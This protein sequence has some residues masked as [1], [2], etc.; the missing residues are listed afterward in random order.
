MKTRMALV[1]L[2]ALSFIGLARPVAALPYSAEY[3]FGDSL[4]DNGN[5]AE[6]LF[7]AN[8]P[9]PPSYH[10]SFTN[11]PVATQLLANSLGLQLAPSLWVTGFTDQYHLFGPGFTPGTNY[12]VAGATSALP[13]GASP[14][15]LAVQVGAY[16]SVNTAA[17]PAA[18]YVIMIGGNDV[19]RAARLTTGAASQTAAV[20]AGVQAELTA[21]QSLAAL[22][23][24][25]FFVVNVPNVGVI[26]EFAMGDPAN[27]PAATQLSQQYDSLLASGIGGLALPGRKIT[28]FDLYGFNANIL[29]NAASYGLTDKTD[30]CYINTPISAATSPQCGPSAQNIGSFAYWDAIHPTAQVQA[31][32]ASGFEAALGVPEPP[33]AALIGGALFGILALGWGRSLRAYTFVPRRSRAR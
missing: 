13:P 19:R 15:S 2:A 11:G 10:D 20:A 6:V 30:P 8:F 4:S 32:W 25:N 3:V 21:I 7:N 18:L 24:R 16:A 14:I 22:G 29:A 17:D 28:Q 12:A 5:L 9:N 31:L 23:A 1:G 27:A 26:P 33:S